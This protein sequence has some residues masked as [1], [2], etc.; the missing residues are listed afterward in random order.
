MN[1]S[2]KMVVLEILLEAAASSKASRS[3][4]APHVAREQRSKVRGSR[5]NLVGQRGQS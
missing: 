3:G 2:F 5:T 4:L 1:T